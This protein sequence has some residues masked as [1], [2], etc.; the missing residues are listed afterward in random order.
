M[1]SGDPSRINNYLAAKQ[2]YWPHHY[3][4]FY[5]DRAVE[6]KFSSVTICK[7]LEYTD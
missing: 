2:S 4:F 1:Y 5:E 3:F 6:N 7:S